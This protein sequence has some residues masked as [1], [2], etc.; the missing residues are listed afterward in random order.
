MCCTSSCQGQGSTEKVFFPF[1]RNQNTDKRELLVLAESGMT[2][3]TIL[4]AKTRPKEVILAVRT[5]AKREVFWP[6]ERYFGQNSS[7]RP[8]QT[9]LA[10]TMKQGNFA[11]YV[12]AVMTAESLPVVPQPRLRWGRVTQTCIYAAFNVMLNPNVSDLNILYNMGYARCISLR[13]TAKC[14]F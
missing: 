13:G 9:L 11:R 5:S 3:V 6:K 12:L 4:L 7:F 8:K 14:S 1:D 10:G 2:A